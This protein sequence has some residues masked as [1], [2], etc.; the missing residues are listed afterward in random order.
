[1]GNPADRIVS[2]ER[3]PGPASTCVLAS[4]ERTAHSGIY[5]LENQS[6]PTKEEIFIRK[7][8]KLPF[9]RECAGPLRFR[10]IKELPYIAEDPDFR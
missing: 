9:C 8:T 5:K 1:M 6:H 2:E 4:G 10:L 7:G 3:R